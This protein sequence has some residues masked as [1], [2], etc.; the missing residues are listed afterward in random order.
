MKS[1]FLAALLAASFPAFAGGPTKTDT[2][3][4]NG[5]CGMCEA[6]IEKAA[7]LRG[8]SAANW[9]ADAKKL[10]VTYNPKKV[11]SED[12]QRMSAMIPTSMLG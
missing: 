1:L 3:T 4:V 2:I 11:T 10:T 7:K 8:V 12:I 6:T 9:D 5:D